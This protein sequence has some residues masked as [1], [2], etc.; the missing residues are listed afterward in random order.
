MDAEITMQLLDLYFFHAGRATYGMFPRQPF[1]TWVETHREKSPDQLMLLYSLLA[2]GSIYSTDDHER[3]LGRRFADVAAYATEKRFGKFTLQLC[4]SRLMLALY[5]FARGRAQE[6]WDFCGAALRAMGALRLNTEEGI[7]GLLDSSTDL[8]YGLDRRTLEE[9]CRRTLW[10]GFLMDVSSTAFTATTALDLMSP[11]RYNGFCGGTVC[12]LNIEDT[13]VRLPCPEN[14][15]EACTPGENPFFD[16]DL[17]SSQAL[18]GLQLGHMAYLILISA[19]WGEVLTFTSRAVH[20]PDTGYERVYETFYAK[21]CERLDVWRNTLPHNLRYTPDNLDAS[22]KEG[23]AGSFISLHALYHATVIRLNRH[24]RVRT[25]PLEQVARNIE[26]CFRNAS[27]F[28]SM[29][30]ALTTVTP[31]GRLPFLSSPFPGYALML[32]VDVLS[33]AGTVPMLHGL[34]ESIGHTVTYM[35]ELGT[36]WSS[37]RTQANAISERLRRLTEIARMDERGVRNGDYGPFWRLPDSLESSFGGEDAVYKADNHV[38]FD[39][40]GKLT[41]H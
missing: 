39:V 26:Q 18:S 7:Q 41:G 13:F 1:R 37:A 2:V 25:L 20:R 35:E 29:I 34:V 9:C 36:F 6:A 4:Q 40:V 24:M 30:H 16:F 17:L 10:S 28:L 5:N 33:S 11:Q 38:L 14:L 8:D 22:V 19:I 31:Q 3:T 27:S 32:S 21:A 23:Y 12:V 15:L